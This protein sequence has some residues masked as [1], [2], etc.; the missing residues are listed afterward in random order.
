MSLTDQKLVYA[1]VLHYKNADDTINCVNSLQQCS[2]KNLKIVVVE[3]FSQNGSGEKIKCA[4]PDLTIIEAN[5]NNGYAGGMNIGAR[6]ALQNNADY[7]L[8][9]NNDMLFEP[10]FIEPLVELSLSDA[11]IGIVSPKVLYMHDKN[12]IYCAG[13][14]Y[15][16]FRCGAVNMYRGMSAN[17]YG[18]EIREITSAEG[19]CLLVKR[20][21]F[22]KVGFINEDYFMY[23]E[24]LDFSTRTREHFKLMYN[25]NS[26]VYH[27]AGAGLNWSNFSPLYY[28]YFTRNR[29]YFYRNS[30]LLMKAYALLYT[31]ANS[32][33]KIIVLLVDSIS[34]NK[35][36]QTVIL[37]NSI[38]KGTTDGIK[39]LFG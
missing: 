23:F 31:V 17:I 20:S 4:L 28:Y 26:V 16:P 34:G 22:E 36:K 29:L 10:D 32:T 6:Y 8:L 25:N 24:D 9:L 11:K 35:G 39:K 7:I 1:I 21:V 38:I 3:N 33:S 5:Q 2:Y 13:G 30:N 19:S 14:E 27:K 12:K 37:I 18:N 15:K